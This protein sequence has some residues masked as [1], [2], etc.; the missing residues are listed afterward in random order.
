MELRNGFQNLRELSVENVVN[1]LPASQVFE[2]GNCKSLCLL[3]DREKEMRQFLNF[4]YKMD[5]PF[6]SINMICFYL[7]S[8]YHEVGG[9]DLKGTQA[10]PGMLALEAQ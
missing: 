1:N 9:K 4:W 2:V 8:M 7:L 10:Y 3:Q 5:G 6:S